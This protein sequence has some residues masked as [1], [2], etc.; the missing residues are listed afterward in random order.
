[1]TC[2]RI[3]STLRQA[4]LYANAVDLREYGD[5]RISHLITF[6]YQSIGDRL[7]PIKKPD[8]TSKYV[9]SGAS[10]PLFSYK[11]NL[12]FILQ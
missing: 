4:T 7:F 2:A 11:K 8:E 12:K 3:A 1:M 9:E 5:S 10:V 6:L